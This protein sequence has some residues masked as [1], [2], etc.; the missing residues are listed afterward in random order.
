MKTSTLLYLEIIIHS[1][2]YMNGRATTRGVLKAHAFFF[3]Q[4]TAVDHNFPSKQQG[5]C[6]LM[7]YIRNSLLHQNQSKYLVDHFDFILVN[8]CDIFFHCFS[9][10]F[11]YIIK[12]SSV[13]SMVIWLVHPI[14]GS[15]CD[16][17]TY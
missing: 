4:E 3:L 17:D 1:T 14:T 10:V 16:K 9:E 15:I 11:C 8:N 6:P 13:F 2:P 7:G 5:I 12:I